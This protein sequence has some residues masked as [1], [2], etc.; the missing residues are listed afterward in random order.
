MTTRNPRYTQKHSSFGQTE[1][2]P[3]QAMVQSV[4]L[5]KPKSRNRI[6][7][8]DL[9]SRKYLINLNGYVQTGLVLERDSNGFLTV[10]WGGIIEH[11]WDDY[12]LTR[13]E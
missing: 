9:V 12:D 13:I 11:M 8:G 10:S 5:S 3:T 6:D 4:Q 1:I 7:P 2:P